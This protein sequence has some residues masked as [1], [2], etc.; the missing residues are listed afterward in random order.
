MLIAQLSDLHITAAP[1]DETARA[2]RRAVSHLLTLPVLPD[3]VLITGDCTEHG[4][5]GEYA[6]FLALIEPLPMPVY[7]V[8]GNHDRRAPMLSALGQPGTQGLDGFMQYVVEAG[9]LRLIGLDTH[10]P[11]HDAGELCETR[12]G[13][14]NERLSEVPERP[15]VIFMHH[16]PTPSGLKVMD[17]IGL[18]DPQVFEA[19]VSRHLQVERVLAGHLHM[20]IT[21]RC[22]GTLLMTAPGTRH[23]W[24]PDLGHPERLSVQLQSPACLL[25]SWTPGAGLVS[26]TS[27]IGDGLYQTL[28][29]HDGTAWRS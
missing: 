23:T 3:L 18:R 6:T 17:G 4:E 2:L 14:L 19:L 26:F 13:W 27:V 29:L 1:D 12:L 24:L 22:G 7:A 15:C 11:G 20:A 28:D 16:P 9:P 25:H 10:L 8:P 21:R 5:V